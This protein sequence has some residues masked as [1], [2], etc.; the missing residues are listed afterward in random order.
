MTRTI[1]HAGAVVAATL[2]TISAGPAVA[3]TGTTQAQPSTTD[4]IRS[5]LGTILGNRSGTTTDNSTLDAQWA[6]G[7]RPLADRRFEFESRIDTEVRSRNLTYAD[8]ERIKGDYRGLVDVEAR[9]GSDGQI[10]RDE[11][12]SL[13]Q[14]YNELTASLERS[15]ASGRGNAGGGY[16]YGGSTNGEIAQGEA[17]FRARVDAQQNAR[18][19][20]RTEASR[21]RS[22]YTALIQLE[23]QYL[24]DGY[25]DN[26][27][28]ADLD[29][30]LD[31]LDARVGDTA[32]SRGNT[33]AS[34][35]QRLDAVASA[36]SGSRLSS[37]AQAQLRVEL[38]DL[39]RLEAAYSRQRAAPDDVAYLESRILNLEERVRI[40]R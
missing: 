6:A 17:A 30:R 35:R 36:I 19:I 4:R 18:R 1:F 27:E 8:G 40:R 3:Q 31:A 13:S 39:M 7:R 32:Y 9:Y 28:R 12:R 37:S 15:L 22:D 34:P 24:R 14:M 26:N 23:Q 29:Q 16:E 33:Y 21:L 2:L 11:R 38:G 10:D 20:S 25:I 5:I